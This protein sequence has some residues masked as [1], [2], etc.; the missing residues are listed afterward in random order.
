MAVGKDYYEI[1]GLKRDAT[2]EEIKKAFRRLAHQHHPDKAGGDAERFKEISEAYQTLSDPEKRQ[3]YDRFGSTAGPSG[4]R[5]EDVQRAGGFDFR[6]ANVDFGDVFGDFFGFGRERRRTTERGADVEVELSIDFR[7]SVFGVEKLLEVSGHHRCD[8]C[9]GRGTEPGSAMVNC[10]TCRGAGVVEHIQHTFFG[11]IRSQTT[12]PSCYGTGERPKI[13]CKHCRGTGAV[14]G[15]HQLR[16]TIPAGIDDGQS[17]RLREQGEPGTRGSRVGDLFVRIRVRP[18]SKFRRDG[19][20]ILTRRT[21]SMM[22]AVLGAK[23]SVETVDGQVQL[24][25]PSGTQSGRLIR[26]S[27]KGVPRLDGKGRGDGIV[28]IVVKI[29]EKLTKEQRE[30]LEQFAEIE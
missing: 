7:E 26:L 20:D 11:G 23:V 16:V 24:T 22:Q 1:L 14:R 15:R 3:R 30:L 13:N 2:L 21:V 4:F 17:I 19:D 28:E 29:P 27:G 18:D 10:T 6:N 5:W 8:R 9:S 12:C 25:V